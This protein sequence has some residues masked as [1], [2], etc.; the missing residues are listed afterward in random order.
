MDEKGIHVVGRGAL[1]S[2]EEQEGMTKDYQ[3]KVK[4]IPIWEMMVKEYGE[5][6]KVDPMSRTVLPGV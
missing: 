2:P 3:K 5:E 4:K 6:N 1:P